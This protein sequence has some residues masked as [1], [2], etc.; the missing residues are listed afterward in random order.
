ML[1]AATAV[2]VAQSWR[3]PNRRPA[4]V[5]VLRPR[6]PSSTIDASTTTAAANDDGGPEM[7]AD[8][9]GTIERIRS[10]LKIAGGRRRIAL[11]G[12]GGISE[13]QRKLI[14]K[15][16]DHVVRFNDMKNLRDGDRTT[17]HVC[18]YRLDC[19]DA[20]YS[21]LSCYRRA[22]P[23]LLI[24]GEDE[25]G[26]C[27]DLND[28]YGVHPC[29]DGR[30]YDV[31]A[32]L[33]RK[34]RVLPSIPE[35]ASAN[36]ATYGPSTGL[37][38]IALFHAMAEVAEIHTFGMNFQFYEKSHSRHEGRLVD[39]YCKKVTVHKTPT[40][41]YEPAGMEYIQKLPLMPDPMEIPGR[42]GG[43]G[44]GGLM[45]GGGMFSSARFPW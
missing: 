9:Q 33:K 18:R 7:L 27:P 38:V 4:A 25:H 8:D 10:V 29:P 26:H 15:D 2:G 16:Y 40:S 24:G 11:V 13:E 23:L 12:N 39:L 37:Y 44:G 20:P 36:E 30:R 32:T 42:R 3:A 5:A 34:T 22:V 31:A 6:Y 14:A 45:G 41:E 19:W 35:A 1:M 43:G 21:G 28:R 17:L